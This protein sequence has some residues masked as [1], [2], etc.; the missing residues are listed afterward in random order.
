M[1]AKRKKTEDVGIN[2]TPMIDIV[3]QLITFFLLV[4]QFAS[5]EIDRAIVLPELDPKESRAVD[6]KPPVKL[7][8]NL[9]AVE[10]GNENDRKMLDYIKAGSLNVTEEAARRGESN[11]L[12]V[13]GEIMDA[14]KKLAEA[15]DTKLV[16]ILRAHKTLQWG[17]VHE[18]M[19]TAAARQL[20]EINLAAPLGDMGL[21]QRRQQ[22]D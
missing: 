4:S 6:I 2:M 3:F 22:Q 1:A 19:M 11:P 15:K 10:K 16:V 18:V 17:S 20:Q 5:A 12:K 9:M 14:Q 21:K 7:V 8:L 13:L